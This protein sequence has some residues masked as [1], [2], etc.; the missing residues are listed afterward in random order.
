MFC[1]LKLTLEN[2]VGLIKT[3]TWWYVVFHSN[4]IQITKA[5]NNMNEPVV[6]Y[7]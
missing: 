4:Q 6:M 2:I 5:R 7:A 1:S 3:G